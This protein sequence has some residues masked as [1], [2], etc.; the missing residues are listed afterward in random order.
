MIRLVPVCLLLMISSLAA[1]EATTNI[2]KTAVLALSVQDCLELA[3]GGNLDLKIEKYRVHSAALDEVI[4]QEEYTGVLELDYQDIKR[5]GPTPTTLGGAEILEEDEQLGELALRKKWT[6][7][8]QTDLI[9]LYRK[10]QSN[11]EF[12]RLNPS[13][14]TATALEITQ[15]LMQGFG[16]KV[17][18]AE[19][20]RA[21]NN[22]VAARDELEVQVEAELLNIFS[23]Y[24]GLVEARFEAELRQKEF[25]IS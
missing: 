8:T 17:N 15:P 16:F 22:W 13:V 10:N 9:W 12:Y 14:Q 2:P 5:E 7:G 18:Q 20:R 11:S 6:L 23:L 21:R 1:Q 4:Q 24:W 19:L 25:E 3:L